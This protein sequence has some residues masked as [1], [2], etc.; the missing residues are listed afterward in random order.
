MVSMVVENR[1]TNYVIQLTP[2]TTPALCDRR[3]R[4]RWACHRVTSSGRSH[5]PCGRSRC[6]WIFW[7]RH[8]DLHCL[9][10]AARGDVAA[11]RR[12]RYGIHRKRRIAVDEKEKRKHTNKS[13]SQA[14]TTWP[15]LFSS[16]NDWRVGMYNTNCAWG[17]NLIAYGN[18]S[19]SFTFLSCK[20]MSLT[21]GS[22][23]IND[24]VGK[25]C[26]DN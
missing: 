26:L 21:K 23:C 25:I 24:S 14:F 3:L 20:N 6:G 22:G 12:P 18:D 13:L 11:I 16:I 9:V 1:Q 10:V 2:V 17:R 15:L 5:S 7:L 19:Q 8:P 4:R